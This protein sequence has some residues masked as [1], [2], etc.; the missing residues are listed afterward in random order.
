MLHNKITTIISEVNDF[1]TSSEKA[2]NSILTILSSLKLPENEYELLN[3]CNSEYRNINK[4]LLPLNFLF[5]E[6]NDPW[7][8]KKSSFYPIM[9]CGKDVFFRFLNDSNILW[10]K[11]SS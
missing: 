9:S 6:F 3:K 8:Y 10:R 2:I 4:L 7:H 11:I 1:F 5:F